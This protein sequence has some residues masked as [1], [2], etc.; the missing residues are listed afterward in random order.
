MAAQKTAADRSCE[1]VPLADAEARLLSLRH[2]TSVMRSQQCITVVAAAAA[3]Q[4][5]LDT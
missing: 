2:V 5:I 4:G 1:A 3:V